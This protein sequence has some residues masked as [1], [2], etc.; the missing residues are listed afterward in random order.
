VNADDVVFQKILSQL[1]ETHYFRHVQVAD[2]RGT[3]LDR[4]HNLLDESLRTG[5]QAALVS[6]STGHND[7][8][9]PAWF[10]IQVRAT[11]ERYLADHLTRKG[12]ECFLPTASIDPTSAG[13]PSESAP[14]LFPGHL[15]C[16]F[17]ARRRLP[18]LLTPGVLGVVGVGQIPAP[19]EEEDIF[20]LQEAIRRQLLLKL[21]RLRPS[22][23]PVKVESGPMAGLTGVLVDCQQAPCLLIE[24]RVLQC[25]VEAR[26]WR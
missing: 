21:L 26:D 2:G 17:S 25:C 14:P 12:F 8:P 13:R 11:A 10:A 9:L 19:A 3:L 6:E 15:F 16:R 5:V 22:G 20:S 4:R 23:N 7:Q 18:L 1:R 24:V